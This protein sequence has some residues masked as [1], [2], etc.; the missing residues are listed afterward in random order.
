MRLRIG[1]AILLA[2]VVPFPQTTVST[3]T[4]QV[5]DESGAPRPNIAVKQIWQNYT[6]ESATHTDTLTTDTTGRVTFPARRLWR[7]LILNAVGT[8]RNHLHGS[9]SYLD[10][11]APG[12]QSFT[13]LCCNSRITL[14]P[15]P[16]PRAQ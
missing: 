6:L 16:E 11:T 7:P 12:L 8:I 9:A 1:I 3:W 5:L 14:H 4:A 13:D 10:A 15:V 2:S